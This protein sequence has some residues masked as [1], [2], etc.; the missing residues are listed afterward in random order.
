[1]RNDLS[2]IDLNI[3]ENKDIKTKVLELSSLGMNYNFANAS[4]ILMILLKTDS[5]V[6]DT[7]EY[8]IEELNGKQ[9][10]YNEKIN[11]FNHSLK[12]SNYYRKTVSTKRKKARIKALIT[13][14]IILLNGLTYKITDNV[15]KDK[16]TDTKYMATREVYDTYTGEIRSSDALEYKPKD[17]YVYIKDYGKVNKNGNRSLKTKSID[18]VEHKDIKEYGDIKLDGEST[19]SN[20][21]YSA[22]DQ[23]TTDEYRIVEKV[24]YDEEEHTKF[25][26]ETYDKIMRIMLYSCLGLSSIETLVLLRYF[27]IAL[28]NDIKT[29]K[30]NK[31][32]KQIKNQQ[33]H[34]VG[35]NDYNKNQIKEYNELKEEALNKT[36]DKDKY[37]KKI[38]N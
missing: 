15:I 21:R 5:R 7:I 25:D 8:K 13:T 26:K 36:L 28:S 17:N 16:Y 3:E 14:G 19:S 33:S 32:L 10:Y 30:A 27:I 23:L 2:K 9:K 35:W 1:M 22:I 38:H 29:K 20:I 6:V 37:L 31:R 11:E 18:S 4:L 12:I 24:T 34:Y